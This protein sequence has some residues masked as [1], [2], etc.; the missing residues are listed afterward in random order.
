MLGEHMLVFS[1]V[2]ALITALVIRYFQKNNPEL[3]LATD[4]AGTRLRAKEA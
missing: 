3:L 2:E 1:L 4:P